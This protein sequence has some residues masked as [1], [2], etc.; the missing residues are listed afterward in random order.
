M[1]F[2]SWGDLNFDCLQHWSRRIGEQHSRS[3]TL[4]VGT[5]EPRNGE[6]HIT[7][8]FLSEGENLLGCCA[9]CALVVGPAVLSF[10]M[11]SHQYDTHGFAML[12]LQWG[13]LAFYNGELT[14]LTNIL[15][16]LA[17]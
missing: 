3:F 6:R 1:F 11:E 2:L 7:E 10:A 13:V 14:T 5:G 12:L 8:I 9:R 16:S 4:V 15:L 17:A